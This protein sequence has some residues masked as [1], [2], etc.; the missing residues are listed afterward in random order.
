MPLMIS[1]HISAVYQL[2][3]RK[4]DKY[5]VSP[6]ILYVNQ[7][8]FNALQLGGVINRSAFF[9]GLYL[10]HAFDN[11]ES[12]MIQAGVSKGVLRFGYS[13]DIPLTSFGVSGGTHEI[14]LI[15]NFADEGASSLNSGGRSPMRSPVF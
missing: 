2:S 15:L 7:G 11:V 10:K 5:F 12:L 3:R 9:G 14:A 6:T 8:T 13:F 1:S 4:K